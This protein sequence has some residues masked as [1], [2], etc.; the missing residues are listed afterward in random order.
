MTLIIGFGHKM[1]NG[2]DEAIKA[3]IAERGR[4]R[5]I[6]K[7]GFGDALKREVN[8]AVAGWGLLPMPPGVSPMQ[9][10]MRA[11]TAQ[12]V[13]RP[14]V[15]YDPDAPMDDPLCPYGKQRSL[16]QWWG[17]NYRRD[18]DPDYWVKKTM[19]RIAQ[20]NPEVALVC[21]VRFENEVIG[22]RDAGGYVVRV[23]RV[24]FAPEGPQHESEKALDHFTDMDWDLC[25]DIPDGRL[26]LLKQEAVNA[27]NFLEAV[28]TLRHAG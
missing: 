28:S 12:G 13:L 22:L 2:K 1:R 26:D 9:D 6:R 15:T 3:I 24:G 27:F 19:K 8:D 23:R 20:D 17:T 14:W 25:L 4:T 5:D 11:L 18:Q 16:L 7:Y 21:D 10:Y